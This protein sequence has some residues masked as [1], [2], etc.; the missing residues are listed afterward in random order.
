MKNKNKKLILSH[1][2]LF[3]PKPELYINGY[4]HFPNF[5]GSL[6]FI[7]TLIIIFI[8]ALFFSIFFSRTINT[9]IINKAFAIPLDDLPI[10]IQIQDSLFETIENSHKL[11]YIAPALATQYVSIDKDTEKQE[12]HFGQI[13]F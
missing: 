11:I 7:I 2:D 1:C 13:F 12:K 3:S 9:Q 10:I 8:S 4:S 5:C 6:F